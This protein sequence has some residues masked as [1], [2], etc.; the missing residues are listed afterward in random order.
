MNKRWT[1]QQAEV[2]F[3]DLMDAC[4]REGP[5]TLTANGD[6]VAVL[7]PIEQWSNLSATK[8]LSIKA[9]LLDD[10]AR[11]NLIIVPRGKSRRR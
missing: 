5:Q 3:D 11:G 4:A 7:V 10:T 6:K 8:S 1:I 2:G 9:L